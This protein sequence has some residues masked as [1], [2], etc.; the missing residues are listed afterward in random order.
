MNAKDAATIKVLS[1]L[2]LRKN[3]P[4][5]PDFENLHPDDATN[6]CL[7]DIQ[8]LFTLPYPKNLS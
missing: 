1:E 2:G 8:R 5:A 6:K 7:D 3:P 4:I